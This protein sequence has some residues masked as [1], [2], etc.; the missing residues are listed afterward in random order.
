M[1]EVTLFWLNSV[2]LMEVWPV[3]MLLLIK[4]LAI[5]GALALLALPPGTMLRMLLTI[6]MEFNGSPQ[7]Q[8]LSISYLSK[9][10]TLRMTA[11]HVKSS[12]V[13]SAL[14]RIYSGVNFICLHCLIK[15]N[16]LWEILGVWTIN[17]AFPS[18]K[19]HW[20]FIV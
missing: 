15:K 3:P 20:C 11:L 17:F 14:Y 8:P 19:F 1:S 7:K 5:L 2:V 13:F 10:Q 6:S 9:F 12:H 4:S 16:I 18:M